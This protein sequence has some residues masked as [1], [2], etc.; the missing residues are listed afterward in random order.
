MIVVIIIFNEF[1]LP[2]LWEIEIIVYLNV[3][4][5]V[6]PKSLLKLEIKN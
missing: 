6:K 1:V 3:I 5:F 4:V 2:F